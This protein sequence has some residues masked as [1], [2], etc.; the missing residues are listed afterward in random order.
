MSKERLTAEEYL[1]ST[2]MGCIYRI[3]KERGF[4]YKFDIGD[5]VALME[6]FAKQAIAERK[7]KAIGVD[8]FCDRLDN[9]FEMGNPTKA[10]IIDAYN[11][12]V[13]E[14][15]PTEELYEVTEIH[16]AP[17]FRKMRVEGGFMYNFYDCKA[18]EYYADWMFVPMHDEFRSRMEDN[19]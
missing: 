13:A 14:R 8:A 19:K 2:P 10:Q 6:A 15:M 5:V 16:N 12:S 7:N 4:V 17:Y 11:K 18:D 3:N 1:Q 9:I